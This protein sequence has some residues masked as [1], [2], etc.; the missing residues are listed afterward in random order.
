MYGKNRTQWGDTDYI[1]ISKVDGVSSKCY[2]KQIEWKK[3][4][5]TEVKMYVQMQVLP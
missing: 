5:R 1:Y 2:P 4:E 3:I